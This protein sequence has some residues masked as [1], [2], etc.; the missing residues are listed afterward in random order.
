MSKKIELGEVTI[1][2]WLPGM[3]DAL[4]EQAE[5]FLGE[6][7]GLDRKQWVLQTL[8][9]AAR[10]HDVKSIPDWIENPAED[11]IISLVV[12]S[13]FSLKFRTRTPEE[14]AARK[15]ERRAK[16]AKKKDARVSRRKAKN[17]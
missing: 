16:R 1:P 3:A 11:A 12:E 9:A 4:I 8:K 2:G 7:D 10:A 15:A 13:I 14:R 17:D 6:A 5:E